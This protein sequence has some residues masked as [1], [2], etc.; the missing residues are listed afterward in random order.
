MATRSTPTNPEHPAAS[1]TTATDLTW[2]SVR[3]AGHDGQLVLAP[4][5]IFGGEVGDH[6]IFHWKAAGLS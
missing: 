2:G 3:W 1:G 5:L 6:L 4:P